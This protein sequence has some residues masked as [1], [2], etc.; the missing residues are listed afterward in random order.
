MILNDC[1]AM[2]FR[3]LDHAYSKNYEFYNATAGK[4]AVAFLIDSRN[5]YQTAG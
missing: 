4:S 5:H 2:Q 1:L 3:F